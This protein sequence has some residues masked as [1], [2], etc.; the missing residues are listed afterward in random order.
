MAHLRSVHLTLCKFDLKEK[1]K[2]EPGRNIE[3]EII[4]HN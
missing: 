1:K 2:K 4:M 3:L